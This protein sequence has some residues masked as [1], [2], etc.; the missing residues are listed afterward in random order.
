MSYSVISLKGG[1]M[2]LRRGILSGSSVEVIT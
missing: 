1:S 2:G